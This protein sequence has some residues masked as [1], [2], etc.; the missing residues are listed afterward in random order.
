MLM[1]FT[2][3]VPFMRGI[4]VGLQSLEKGGGWG[5]DLPRR[6]RCLWGW[7]GEGCCDSTGS[8]AE[9]FRQACS[10]VRRELLGGGQPSVGLV[11]ACVQL[12]YGVR[13][14]G[15]AGECSDDIHELSASRLGGLVFQDRTCYVASPH[16]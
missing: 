7:H 15:V 4:L 10:F 3:K 9:V 11:H 2:S 14:V 8:W 5:G 6:S 12:P 13:V 16:P 1:V